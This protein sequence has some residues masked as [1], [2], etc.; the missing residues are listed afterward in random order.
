MAMMTK[1]YVFSKAAMCIEENFK[2][3][4]FR[5]IKSN[6]RILKKYYGGFNLILLH[7]LDYSPIFQIELFLSVRIDIVENIVNDFIPNRNPQ[8]MKYTETIGT[9]YKELSGAKE[10]L[11]EISTE[12]ELDNAINEFIK[13]IRD[14]GLAFFEKYQNIEMVNAEI[15][16]QILNKE[17]NYIGIIMQSLSLMKLCNDPDF[18]VLCDKYKELYV[19]FVGEEIKGR[20]AL[21]NLIKYLKAM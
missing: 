17:Y 12:K 6:S 20:E 19:P 7:V 13:I 10:N 18:D 3:E 14:K 2:L 15:K 16:K 21:D 4:G 9:S 5:F 1:R 11:I 8:F